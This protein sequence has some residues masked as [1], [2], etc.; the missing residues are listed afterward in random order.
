M[1][2]HEQN[3]SRCAAGVSDGVDAIGKGGILHSS[4]QLA[5][6]FLAVS[7]LAGCLTTRSPAAARIK[8]ADNA[9]VAGC[10]YVGEVYGSDQNSPAD[11]GMENA[12][13]EALEQAA[14]KRATHVVWNALVASE[15]TSVSGKAYLC[16][17][18]TP[19]PPKT[20]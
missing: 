3:F 4:W 11:V 6:A 8:E 1:T 12:K 16:P 2:C 14:S 15:H 7:G 19:N 9:M 10:T 5:A 20:P 18:P 17:A 13:T